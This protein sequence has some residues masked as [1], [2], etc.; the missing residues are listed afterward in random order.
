MLVPSLAKHLL[1]QLKHRKPLHQ[2]SWNSVRDAFATRFQKA[3]GPPT[4]ASTCRR[5]HPMRFQFIDQGWEGEF[6]K[7][8]NDSNGKLRLICPFIQTGPVQTPTWKRARWANR[9]DHAFQP[10]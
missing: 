5:S 7:A 6:R 8:L 4:A 3:E 1:K 10:G 2:T 9:S